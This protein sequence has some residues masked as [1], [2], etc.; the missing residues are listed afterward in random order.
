MNEE[1]LILYESYFKNVHN[2]KIFIDELPFHHCSFCWPE[3]IIKVKYCKTNM[4]KI[5]L[6]Y[7]NHLKLMSYPWEKVKYFLKSIRISGFLANNCVGKW[8]MIKWQ[9]KD[10]YIFYVVLNNNFLDFL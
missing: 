3:E 1:T 9:E 6:E 4:N 5:I 7:L 8:M 10:I 2:Y